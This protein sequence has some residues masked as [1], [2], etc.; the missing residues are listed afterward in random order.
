MNPSKSYKEIN[1]GQ[2]RGHLIFDPALIAHINNA[3]VQRARVN[4]HN[5]NKFFKAFETADLKTLK[6]IPHKVTFNLKG[7]Q[8]AGYLYLF[9]FQARP[10]CV[11]IR[12]KE[13]DLYQNTTDQSIDQRAQSLGRK[14]E[15]SYEYIMVKH[16]FNEY[17]Y[18]GTLF[19]GNFLQINQHQNIFLIND[20]LIWKDR[21][22]LD[23]LSEKIQ[24]LND[25]FRNKYSSDP[26][27]DTHQILLKEY[28]EYD[29]IIDFTTNYRNMLPYRNLINGVIFRPEIRSQKLIYL[30]LNRPNQVAGLEFIESLTPTPAPTP[31]PTTITAATISVPKKIDQIESLA[32]V[33][34]GQSREKTGKPT[35]D[36]VKNP[37]VVF[38]MK[39]TA[40]PDVYELYLRDLEPKYGIAAVTGLALSEEIRKW[41]PPA[42]EAKEVEEIV[43]EA[44]Y[45][46]TFNKWRPTKCIKDGLVSSFNDIQV[47]NK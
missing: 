18:H 1:F 14:P 9:K 16:R 38:R 2:G 5:G 25:V 22:H 8:T 28:C 33:G 34:L 37:K 30:V 44:E 13:V 10:Y 31:A 21:A 47:Y 27:L 6:E 17:L 46:A 15:K 3:I 12:E 39:K 23:S 45:L 26:G 19:Q 11:Y 35:I 7:R 42:G 36:H 41:F 4:L 43:V 40:K 24:L 20:L 32:S 29:Q